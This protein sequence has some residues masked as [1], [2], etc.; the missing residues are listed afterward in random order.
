MNGTGRPP[1]IP[2]LDVTY[3]SESWRGDAACPGTFMEVMFNP[4]AENL[5]MSLCDL[6][7]VFDECE[8]YATE[9]KP[10]AGI[11]AGQDS[12]KRERERRA[13]LKQKRVARG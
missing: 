1:L 13:D 2:T 4:D 3:D 7:P 5:A 11:W 9:F 12:R 10:P 6:C 8:I